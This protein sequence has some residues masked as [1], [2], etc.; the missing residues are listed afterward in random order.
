MSDAPTPCTRCGRPLR[1]ATSIARG[2]GPGCAR[3]IREVAAAATDVVNADTIAKAVEDIED[4]ALIDTRRVTAAGRRVFAVVSSRGDATYLA[5]TQ[6][7]TCRGGHRGRICR[8][9]VA[10]ALLAA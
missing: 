6:T 2:T 9:R 3:R 4:G 8:H 10:V 7:C 1:A 5:T